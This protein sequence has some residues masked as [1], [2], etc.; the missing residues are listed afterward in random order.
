M[1]D[2]NLADINGKTLMHYLAQ[3][4]SLDS[5]DYFIKIFG[6]DSINFDAE[7][8]HRNTPLSIAIAFKHIDFAK[9]LIG[10]QKVKL[11]SFIY[12]EKLQRP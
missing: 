8:V 10:L 1:I 12:E 11:L 6:E 2:V 5:L 4:G 3:R 7:D 9:K